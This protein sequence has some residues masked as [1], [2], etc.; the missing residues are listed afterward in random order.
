M[1]LLVAAGA[2]ADALAVSV[3]IGRYA[4]EEAA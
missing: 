4:A 1:T 3:T 2:S